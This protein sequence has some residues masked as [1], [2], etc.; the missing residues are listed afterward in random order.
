MYPPLRGLLFLAG[1]PYM[2]LYV[3]I[4]IISGRNKYLK[5]SESR[6]MRLASQAI[7]RSCLGREGSVKG[8]KAK[9]QLSQTYIGFLFLGVLDF[10][11]TPFTPSHLTLFFL[12][13]S[14]FFLY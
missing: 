13:L 11:F 1:N 6:Q 4:T 10:A 7:Q 2:I 9:N 3:Y 8:V 5:I 14:F 12:S